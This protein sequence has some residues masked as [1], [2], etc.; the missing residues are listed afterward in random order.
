MVHIIKSRKFVPTG[1]YSALL[2][3]AFSSE[4]YAF[5]TMFLTIWPEVQ[6]NR[7][8]SVSKILHCTIVYVHLHLSL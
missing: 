8:I 7:N 1:I 3:G 5:K 4:I 6:S 2:N